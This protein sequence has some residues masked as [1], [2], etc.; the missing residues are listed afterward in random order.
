[1]A[2]DSCGRFAYVAN[3][4]SNNVSAYSIGE[5]G[6]LTPVD[7]SLDSDVG[8]SQPANCHWSVGAAVA[9]GA[10]FRGVTLARPPD[11][12]VIGVQAPLGQ[13]FLYVAIREREAQIPTDGQENHLRF[14]LA[15]PEQTGNRRHTEHPSI[16]AARLSGQASKV[17]T[18]PFFQHLGMYV[19]WLRRAICPN[20]KPSFN[21]KTRASIALRSAR[22]S[23]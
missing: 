9:I 23:R 21:V 17:A 6:A 7:G 2:V 13:E 20:S 14:K 15:P 18:L 3:V 11:G 22:A 8:Q 16:L 5:N 1:M 12:D 10:D 4:I 19:S